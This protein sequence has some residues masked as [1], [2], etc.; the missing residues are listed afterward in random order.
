MLMRRLLGLPGLVI[1]G[2]V[3]LLLVLLLLLLIPQIPHLEA[4][5]STRMSMA[6]AHDGP[7]RRANLPSSL[8]FARVA[9]CPANIALGP[10]LGSL[11][12][13]LCTSI[14]LFRLAAHGRALLLHEGRRRRRHVVALAASG[15]GVD[16]VGVVALVKVLLLLLLLGM[17]LL[18]LGVAQ[19][20]A[21]SLG[22]K[23]SDEGH[24]R[25]RFVERC[26]KS[27]VEEYLSDTEQTKVLMCLCVVNIPLPSGLSHHSYMLHPLLL[28]PI[29]P[30]PKV[31]V[32][33]TPTNQAS[34]VAVFC[35]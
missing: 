23:S 34:R 17:L 20:R 21:E 28:T 35:R 26:A 18:I 29:P 32:F 5:A 25:C 11:Q 1:L 19:E 8:S 3:L 31:V 6:T 4:T 22:D 16:V 33:S 24:C 15:I 2:L 7:K 13:A 27:D 10:M 9:L 30:T 12:G 14:V